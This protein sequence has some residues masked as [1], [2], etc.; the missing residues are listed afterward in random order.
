MTGYKSQFFIF[1]VLLLA[2]YLLLCAAVF[3][4]T[5]RVAES[6]VLVLRQADREL[7]REDYAAALAA[8]QVAIQRAPGDIRGYTGA[9]AALR[10]LDRPADA[11]NMDAL[12]DIVGG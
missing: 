7:A 6:P 4:L 12:A 5:R 3:P 11:D 2:V 8:F 10:G 1:L 9:A